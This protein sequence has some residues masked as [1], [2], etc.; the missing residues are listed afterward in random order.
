MHRAL[1][2]DAP[3]ELSGDRFVAVRVADPVRREAPLD[4]SAVVLAL[5]EDGCTARSLRAPSA[6]DHGRDGGNLA[7]PVASRT[8]SR[9][10]SGNRRLVLVVRGAQDAGESQ[11]VRGVCDLEL[12]AGRTVVTDAHLSVDRIC[13]RSEDDAVAEDQVCGGE[14]V[15][16]HAQGGVARGFLRGS[17]TLSF[18]GD[19][20]PVEEI[21]KKP[22]SD[23][24]GDI[25]LGAVLGDGDLLAALPGIEIPPQKWVDGTDEQAAVLRLLV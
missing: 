5:V 16:E 6:V 10:L 7:G 12:Q 11:E 1:G 20:R 14:L 23:R 24:C 25:G 15:E 22:A 9:G 2:L 4:Q 8:Y 21:G 19:L 3:T 13:G 18:S 17:D